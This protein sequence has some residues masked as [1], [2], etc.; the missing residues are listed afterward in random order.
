MAEYQS[1][2]AAQTSQ[3]TA[4]QDRAEVLNR[5]Y[6]FFARHYQ[7]GDFIVERRYGK[8]GAR[9]VKS[10]GED[11]EFHWA[12]EDMYYIKSG[13][14]FT[15]FPVTLASGQRIV[16]SVEPSSLQATRAALKP[17]D[18]AHYALDSITSAEGDALQVRLLYLKGAQTEK[19][20]E[21]I[22][23]AV[24]QASH[25]T[26]AEAGLEIR[27]W[28]QRLL[29][30]NQSDFFIHK[31]LKEALSADLDI[32]LK[33]EVLDVDQ[34]LANHATATD[35]PQRAL[36]VARIVRDIG[37]Q[38]I[39]FLATL[40]DFQKALWEK[41]KLVF[42][43]RYVITLDRLERYCPHWLAQNIN[44]IVQR[45]RAEWQTLGLGDYPQASACIRQTEGDLATPASQRYLPL[46]LDTQNFDSAFQWA[47][48]EAI[49]A[50]APLDDNLD[51]IVIQSD[52]WQALNSIVNRYKN[53]VNCIYT[54]PPYN[55]DA[56]PISYKNGY[57]HA[58]WLTLI[59]DRLRL[60]K[61]FLIDSGIH[62]ITIDDYE[63]HRLRNLAETTI[64]EYNFL[65]VALIKNNPAGRTGTTGF[66]ACHEYAYFYGMSNTAQIDRL[67]HSEAQKSRYKEKDEIG[68]F[69]WTNFRKHGGLNTYKTT[70]PRQFY[71]IYVNGKSIRIPEMNWDNL[72]RQY[73]INEPPLE[74]EE[75]LLPIDEKG[76]E[77][78]WDF[79]VD[80]AKENISH[81]KVKK[82]SRG[83]TAIYRKWRINEDGLLPQTWWEKKQYSAAEYGTNLLT[84][85][86]GSSHIFMFPK[87]V[88][89]V[90]DCLKVSGLRSDQSGLVL[91]FFA[92]SGT[93]GHAVIKLNK[94]DAG[95][96]KFLLVEANQYIDQVTIPRLK[97]V[98][99]ASDWLGGKTDKLDGIGIFM[100]VQQLEQYEDTLENLD[101]DLP[102]GDSAD[103]LFQDPAFAL[104]YRL[105]SSAHALYCAVERFASP[106]GY[107]L[108]RA[109]GGGQAQLHNVDLLESMP[110]LLGL[111][112]SRLYRQDQ[113]AVLLG[114]NRQGQSVA[115]F[116]RDC[117]MPD[118]A[119]WLQTK[120]AQ[121]PAD[122][123][124]TNDPA[125]LSFQGCE[126]FEAI[127]GIF[128]Q[129]FEKH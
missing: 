112:V 74:N 28:L 108:K 52:N 36:K 126:Q 88:Y 62:C 9:Y 70:R 94:Q 2:V 73:K 6:Q 82:D 51:G 17:N 77:R 44:H 111:Q 43:T 19:Q 89:A 23:R 18:K 79:V 124:Y 75:V 95:N 34:L 129:Q 113:G 116:F 86:F 45:Q 97:K 100:R 127:E 90:A 50:A 105:D 26:S 128:A 30:R 7:D 3:Q 38:I 102:Q 8:N 64:S 24:Q 61:N 47:M 85:L 13:D 60:T 21:D 91:D 80:T 117:A 93:T 87:S 15:D 49:T 109:V 54:D 76:N 31:R 98:S 125:S 41:K 59:Q 107:Q 5:L 12:T 122:R 81:L 33:T 53:E 55:S 48:L 57:R 78:I 65:G 40:E 106:F 68:F 32:F 103:L 123:V 42:A 22:V 83:E 110:Y 1:R 66:S 46:P 37:M 16:F 14:I 121:H 69:E 20:K 35:L 114:H 29:A 104:R 84:K 92:G 71:P 101:S 63:A 118:T 27:R 4:Q 67:E 58:S 39:D 25:S 120:L 11:T 72:S 99:A 119:Q 96:R 10:T 115:V 56:G